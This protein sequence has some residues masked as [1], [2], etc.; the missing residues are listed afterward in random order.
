MYNPE[1]KISTNAFGDNDKQIPAENHHRI[2]REKLNHIL[3][4][5]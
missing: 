5:Y 2:L 1:W 3:K 4:I